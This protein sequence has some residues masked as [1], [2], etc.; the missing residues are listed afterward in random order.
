MSARPKT[1][2]WGVFGRASAAVLLATC[3]I[4]LAQPV[5]AFQARLDSFDASESTIA[6]VHDALMSGTASCRDIVSSFIARIEAFNPTINAIM[7]LNP[8]ALEIANL[9]MR[10][11]VGNTTGKLFCVPVLLKDSFDATPMYTT[12]SSLALARNLPQAD[13]PV[14]DAF[15]KEGAVILG[16]TSLHEMALEGI[17]VSSLGGQTINPYDHTRTPGGSS[18]GTGAA[19]AASFSVFGTGTDT[20]NSLRSPASANNLVSVRPT[21]GLIS[22]SGVIPVSHTQDTIGPIARTIDDLAVALTV[23]ASVGSDPSDNVTLMVPADERAK[24]YSENL[25]LGQLQGLRIGL[26]DGFWNH[27]GSDET[28]PVNRVMEETL[29]FL[30]G[31]GVRIVNITDS[32]YNATRIGAALDVQRYEYKEV[33][34]AYLGSPG[35]EGDGPRSF[36]ELYASKKFFVLPYQYTFI[37][38]ALYSST[39]NESY[40]AA[41]HGVNVLAQTLKDTFEENQLSAI[42]Y[43][44]QRNLVVKLGS[45]SQVGRNGILAALTGHPVVTI[46][47]G[48]STPTEDAPLGVPV[49][50]ELLGMPYSEDRLLQM[51][52]QITHTRPLRR[53]PLFSQDM[54]EMSTYSTVPAIRPAKDNISPSYPIGVLS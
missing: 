29:G 39:R 1:T 31:Q 32:I 48:F 53:A 27:T 25:H 36:A 3:L 44:E 52:W 50:L 4:A 54:V 43:P 9:D 47:A 11:R 2:A 21:R 26:L 28:T 38:S 5:Y 37:Q 30:K 40:K 16:K 45:L 49:G 18:G 13:G 19:V 6:S 12:G 23:M 8:R 20:M 34:D 15:R 14:V 10:L 42:M 35:L 33:L 22:R 51:A 17:S 24:D 41:L 7:T 46:P